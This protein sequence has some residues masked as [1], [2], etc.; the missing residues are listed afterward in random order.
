MAVSQQIAIKN[1]IHVHLETTNKSF[2]DVH[3]FL[4]AKGIKNN[5]FF[6][7]LYDTDLIGVNPF[8]PNNSTLY[9]Q[10]ILRECM[11]N[12]WYWLRECVILNTEG[13]NMSQGTRYKLHRGNLAMNFLSVLNFNIFLELPRQHGKTTAAV[14]RYLWIFTIGTTNSQIMFIHKN[15]DGSKENLQRLKNYREALP[16]FLRIDSMVGANGKQ[17]RVPNTVETLEN[18]ANH[19]SIKTLPSARNKMLANT[20][21][22]GCTQPLQY[23]DEFAWI[24]HN[25]LIYESATPAFSRA[26]Q[27]ARAAGAPYGI[28]LT[29]TPG[30]L[31]TKE[32]EFAYK[33]RNDA[34]PFQEE[35]YDYTL[36]Q[37]NNLREANT[38]S[39]FFHVKYSYLQ[40]GSSEEYFKEQVKQLNK[41]FVAVR[42]EILLEWSDVSED[43]PF[44]KED[45]DII[46][47]FCKAP[48]R[49][50]MFGPYG[51][52][53]MLIYQEMDPRHGQIIGVDVAGGMR[54][55]SSAITV[56]DATSTEVV[57]TLNCNYMPLQDLASTIFELVTQYLPN[58]LVAIERNGI[59]HGVI[60]TLMGTIIKRNLYYEIEERALTER[61]NGVTVDRGKHMVKAYGINNSG[62]IRARMIEILFSRVQYHKDK[63]I[64]RILHDEMAGLT[65][66]TSR[67]G[68]KVRI[69][70]SVNTHDDQIF[71][72]LMAMYVW[73]DCKDLTARFGI[74]RGEIKTDDDIEEKL[75]AI[76]DLYSDT[77]EEIEINNDDE[78]E[79]TPVLD[80]YE[81]KKILHDAQI[82]LRTT[83]TLEREEY[84][85]DIAVL[86][87]I[88][89]NPVGREAV[90]KAYN[91]DL[92]QTNLYGLDNSYMYGAQGLPQQIYDEWY[93]DDD[94][95]AA[96]RSREFNGNLYS[97]FSNIDDF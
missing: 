77:Y 46:A 40:L 73:Y 24:L 51:Q 80:D 20:L 32:G 26:S 42:R 78:Y 4:K 91:I 56:L 93:S 90:A 95:I 39:A 35:Y 44:S 31:T 70:H 3:Y 27:N 34:T 43:C 10:K 22:R 8:D 66:R 45:L 33:M 63:F 50:L 7:S 84:D 49:V 96:A 53:Q 61:T 89:K 83:K 14:L 41:N 23:Y 37:L 30:D 2:L 68:G 13:S 29:T 59:G 76:E 6:L 81:T 15:H 11:L 67:Q 65:Y 92:S 94:E 74:I 1:M 97:E 62:A 18:P 82:P 19:N 47:Q 75:G 38:N 64:A 16:S 36:D 54:R 12:Y 79:Q 21:G 58:A 57:A 85:K 52:Y 55:D 72:Y 88:I 87:E 60:A 28:I 69:D 5:A 25:Q 71:S 9:K 48:M 86:Q 17:I